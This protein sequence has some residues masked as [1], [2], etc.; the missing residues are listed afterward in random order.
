MCIKTVWIDNYPNY[1][2]DTNGNI[3]SV[4][5]GKYLK[6]TVRQ[7]GYCQVGL[8]YIPNKQRKEYIHVLVAKT[9]MKG[10]NFPPMQ[11]NHIDGDKTNNRLENLEIISPSENIKHGFKL[12]RN[13][14][15]KLKKGEIWL[16]R[17]LLKEY[18]KPQTRGRGAP[19]IAKMFQVTHMAIYYIKNKPRLIVEER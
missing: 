2:I 3:L 6:P 12:G 10:W 19:F 5:S 16:I 13:I 18:Y 7:D 14:Q 11:V 17:K 4:L 8:Y 9:F 1:L 15:H